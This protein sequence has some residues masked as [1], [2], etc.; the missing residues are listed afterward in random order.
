MAIDRLGS[1]LQKICE[2]S[3]G[4]MKKAT[5]LQLGQRLVRLVPRVHSHHVKMQA[6][7]FC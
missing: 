3:G 2:R 4:R 1:D 6:Q 5:V 7:S